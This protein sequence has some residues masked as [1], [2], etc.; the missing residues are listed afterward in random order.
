M[1]IQ[2]VE[3]ARDYMQKLANGINPLDDSPVPEYELINHVRL[4]RCFFFVADLLGQVLS[5][6]PPVPKKPKKQPFALPLDVRAAFAFSQEPITIS[7]ITRR[8]NLL[9]DPVS[10]KKLPVTSLTGWLKANGLL[11]VQT[12]PK[13]KNHTVPT[14][15]GADMGI[16][17]QERIGQY[18]PYIAVVYELRMQQFILDNLDGAIQQEKAKTENDD[19]PWTLEEDAQLR[20]LLASGIPI[21]EIAQSLKRTTTTIRSRLRK[22]GLI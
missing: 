6:K 1:D 5:E 11:Q 21:R 2:S 10:M 4:S 15:L 13:G 3:Q 9:I 18:G 22:L 20:T 7:E 8:I 16:Y 12:D 14:Q 17:T 19:K